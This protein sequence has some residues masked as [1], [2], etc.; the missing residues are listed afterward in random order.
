MK[1]GEQNSPPGPGTEILRSIVAAPVVLPSM[2]VYTFMLLLVWVL[3]V[4]FRRRGFR[5]GRCQ[6]PGAS[7]YL[8]G[9]GE[10][11]RASSHSGPELE[12]P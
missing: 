9:A 3:V 10:A 2:V 8:R 5:P 6:E 11:R 4:P 1:Y 7:Q 12:R